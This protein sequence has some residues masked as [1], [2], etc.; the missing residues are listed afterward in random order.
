MVPCLSD[1]DLQVNDTLQKIGSSSERL[2]I[3]H[4]ETV[5]KSKCMPYSKSFS[6]DRHALDTRR[7][8]HQ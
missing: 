2:T 1:D 5:R 6:N 8:L 3:Q 7:M 4:T